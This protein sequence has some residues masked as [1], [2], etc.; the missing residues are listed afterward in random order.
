MKKLGS[1]WLVLIGAIVVGVLAFLAAIAVGNAQKP[2]TVSVLAVTRDLNV[3][4]VIQ[5][6]DLTTVNVY[7]DASTS[8][9]IPA[10]Q[11]VALVGGWVA[12]PILSGQ[13]VARQNII[14]SAG[15]G[16]RLSASLAKWGADY[17][18]FTIPLDAT[19]IV[20]PG[21]EAFMPGDL[22][23][24][25]MS[26]SHQ[27][28]EPTTPTPTPG[29]PIAESTPVPISI[30]KTQS[31]ADNRIYPPLAADLFPGGLRVI[32]TY[33][34]STAIEAAPT[35][36][37]GGTSSMYQTSS[38]GV[39]QPT[40]IIV[41]VPQDKVEELSFAL[42]SSDKVYISLMAVGSNTPTTSFSYW[43]L[44]DLLKSQRDQV[45]GGGKK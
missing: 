41:L 44:E 16:E 1:N 42:M 10:N 29:G 15:I 18:L 38:S 4:D 24:I 11:Q 37:S 20:S 14:A 32:A 31:D 35:A 7:K 45:L 13:P 3:G 17:R 12:I 9:Y 30:N 23:G 6:T 27:P 34:K 25:T 28:Q 2:S 8:Y 40:Y 43:D 5:A 36:S 33:G 26:I 22:I 21:I 39:N 19:N